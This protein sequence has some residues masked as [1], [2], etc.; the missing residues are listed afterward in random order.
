MFEH[1]YRAND[2][3]D[4]NLRRLE[5]DNTNCTV[6]FMF[7]N[8]RLTM[9]EDGVLTTNAANGFHM[10]ASASLVNVKSIVLPNTLD[11]NRMF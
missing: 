2:S 6:A 5:F 8:T 10:F 11:C 1:L 7:R 4:V 3:V 9:K